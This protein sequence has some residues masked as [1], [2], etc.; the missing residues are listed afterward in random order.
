ML[1]L[2]DFGRGATGAVDGQTMLNLTAFIATP[3]P[4]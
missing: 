1:S 4:S 3:V 2:L